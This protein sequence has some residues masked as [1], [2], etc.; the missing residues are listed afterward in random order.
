MISLLYEPLPCS[1]EVGGREVGILTDF[2]AWLQFIGLM[3]DK[4]LHDAEKVAALQNWLVEPEPVTGQIVEGLAA[5]C[6]ASH[7]EPERPEPDEGAGVRPPV[8]DWKIDAPFIL[9]DFRRFYG[10]DLLRLGYLHWWEFKA[11]F[12][13][14]PPDSRVMD[15]IRLRSWDLSKEKNADRRREIAKAQ[16]M[17]ALPFALTDD[18][19]GDVFASAL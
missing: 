3:Q 15:R 9:G 7:L 1:I 10:M 5:F 12:L 11:L 4:E 13:A 6:K 8:F 18:M 2:R 17:I 16:R 14:L 19:I